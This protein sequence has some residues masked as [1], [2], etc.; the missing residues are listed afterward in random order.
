MPNS[1][2]IIPITTLADKYKF[3]L[4]VMFLAVAAGIII[5]E[6]ISKV[7]ISLM[8]IATVK[9]KISKNNNSSLCGLMPMDEA[10]SGE[11]NVMIN[12][13]LK[14]KRRHI[15][16]KETVIAIQKSKTLTL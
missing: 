5:S 4:P 1:A 15:T 3:M 14:Y 6:P 2:P 11:I 10:K 12:F 9:E 8:P 16:K 7:P 13:L